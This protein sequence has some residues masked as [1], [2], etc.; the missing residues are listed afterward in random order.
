MQ[1]S[2]GQ[3]TRT[4]TNHSGTEEETG[5]KTLWSEQPIPLV[6]RTANGT[7]ELAKNT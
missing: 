2:P 3:Q 4:E 7:T 1:S 5:G 6:K